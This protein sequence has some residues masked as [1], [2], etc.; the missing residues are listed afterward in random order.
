MAV[1]ADAALAA[2]RAAGDAERAAGMAA[3]HKAP[4]VYLGVSVPEIDAMAK[5]WRAELTLDE[6][7]SLAAALWDSDVHEAM[8][9]AAK[10]LTQARIRPDDADAWALVCSWVPRFDAWAVADHATIAGQKRVVADPSRIGTVDGWTTHPNMWTRRAA[11]VITLPFARLNHPKPADLAIRERALGWAA[12]Y[13][14]DRDWFIQKA[15]AW[16]VRDLSRHDAA[17]ARAFL[18]GPGTGLKAFARKEAARHLP[19]AG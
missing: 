13:V 11:L 17:R 4:R 2:L 6:R 15:V 8:V 10:L 5:A 18:D 1:T 3:Y 7:L 9:A 16:W 19:P 14:A 12:G